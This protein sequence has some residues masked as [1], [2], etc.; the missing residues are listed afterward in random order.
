M[1]FG[2]ICHPCLYWIKVN[3][4]LCIFGISNF[5]QHGN[6]F[7]IYMVSTDIW[8]VVFDA[9]IPKIVSLL[10]WIPFGDIVSQ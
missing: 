7:R 8:E 10:V 2:M 3:A 5:F 9:P 1:A 4:L 6:Y